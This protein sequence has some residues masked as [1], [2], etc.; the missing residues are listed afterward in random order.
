M[1]FSQWTSAALLLSG[2]V[3]AAKY[4]EYILAPRSRTLYPANVHG[5]NGSISGT[6]SLI[7]STGG[8]AVFDGI[9][10]VTYDFGKNIAGFVTLQIGDVDEDQFIGL[11]YTESSLWISNIS[12]DATEDAGMDEPYWFQPTEGGNFTTDKDHGRG[13]FRYLTLVHNTTQSNRSQSTS[14]PC[15]IMM[16]ARSPTTQATSIVMMSC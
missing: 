14:R 6:D 7:G 4:E 1:P 15:L 3:A 12:S 9:S 16:R 5:F 10:A 2:V 11:T 13:G 8:E